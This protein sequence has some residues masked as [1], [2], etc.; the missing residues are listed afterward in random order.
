M[1]NKHVKSLLEKLND[2]CARALEN[3]AAFASTR[4][5]YEVSID[6]FVIKLME[7]VIWRGC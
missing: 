7:E 4:T 2:Y 3:A 5:H 1:K 6:H